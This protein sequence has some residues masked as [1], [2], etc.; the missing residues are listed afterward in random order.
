MSSLT[1][2]QRKERCDDTASSKQQ[3]SD[4]R[5]RL[6]ELSARRG[7]VGAKVRSR[8]GEEVTSPWGCPAFGAQVCGGST[9]G[10]DHDHTVT[11]VCVALMTSTGDVFTRAA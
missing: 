5:G 9:E 6:Q 10:A 4:K 11:S 1:D 2:P 7:R 8:E 3:P